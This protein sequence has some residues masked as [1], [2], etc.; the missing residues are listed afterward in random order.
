MACGG[1]NTKYQMPNAERTTASVSRVAAPVRS[2]ARGVTVGRVRVPRRRC[3]LPLGL[4]SHCLLRGAQGGASRA[5]RTLAPVHVCTNQ[6]INT[7]RPHPTT[8]MRADHSRSD[9]LSCQSTRLVLG[10][11]GDVERREA[12]VRDHLRCRAHRRSDA[13][14]STQIKSNRLKST[15]ATKSNAIESQRTK[16]NS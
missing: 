2:V 8:R 7:P 13:I 12:R 1:G 15:H 3:R 11:G 5:A 10:V 4:R 6:S 16:P 9:R 14:N